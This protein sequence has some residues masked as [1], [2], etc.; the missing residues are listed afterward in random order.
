MVA[1]NH[2]ALCR[3][4]AWSPACCAADPI[5]LLAYSQPH[6]LLRSVPPWLEFVRS[7]KLQTFILFSF[8]FFFFFLHF[9][10]FLSFLFFFTC[11][12][13]FW[14][15]R[16]SAQQALEAD[17]PLSLLGFGAALNCLDAVVRP[18]SLRR[19]VFPLSLCPSLSFR[20]LTSPPRALVTHCFRR[21]HDPLLLASI[22]PSPLSS[23]RHHITVYHTLA[24]VAPA[25]AAALSSFRQAQ[26]RLK[27][28]R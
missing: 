14:R 9:F 28:Y 10:S 8:F 15:D 17:E 4:S 19:A 26:L 1:V 24:A 21:N 20:A 11:I 16:D 5:C 18:S 23:T 12:Q 7:S 25:P 22:L 13:K 27:R 2:S 3:C 6:L